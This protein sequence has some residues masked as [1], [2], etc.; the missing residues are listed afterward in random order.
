MFRRTLLFAV[1]VVSLATPSFGAV[2]DV[3]TFLATGDG[4]TDDSAAVQA[5]YNCAASPAGGTVIF[6]SG[7]PATTNIGVYYLANTVSVSG[8]HITTR[9][10]DVTLKNGNSGGIGSR[11][12]LFTGSH[13]TFDGSVTLDQN[14]KAVY[15]V[16]FVG[17]ASPLAPVTNIVWKAATDVKRGGAAFGHA[18]SAYLATDMV[19]RNLRTS[20]SVLVYARNC[21]RYEISNVRVA[22]TAPVSQQILFLADAITSHSSMDITLSDIDMDLGNQNVST[23]I[24]VGA[25]THTT[26]AFDGVKISNV[27][28]RNTVGSATPSDGI[29]LIDC[30]NAT[31]SNL[32]L[33]DID[34]NGINAAGNNLVLTNIVGQNCG[35]ACVQIHDASN[36]NSFS[37][38]TLTNIIVVNGGNASGATGPAA[39]GVALAPRYLGGGAGGSLSLVR[40]QNVHTYGGSTPYGLYIS[41]NVTY[42]T[43]EGLSASGSIKGI[44]LEDPNATT[45]AF[46]TPTADPWTS[47][48]MA[49]SYYDGTGW[50]RQD[51]AR[52]AGKLSADYFG[53]L[54]MQSAAA[55]PNPITWST[56]LML[57]SNG[58]LQWN[59]GSPILKHLSA[60]FGLNL[61][62]PASVPGCVQ[63]AA[64]TLTGA[65]VGNPVAAGISVA[66]PSNQQLTAVVTAAGTVVFRVCQFSG[67]AVDPDGGGATYRADVWQH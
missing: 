16:D 64:Q 48:L 59:G 23:V 7:K 54:F 20:D 63:S 49:N 61:A 22:L 21:R 50:A 67:A 18:M 38:V 31:V 15:A 62:A 25:G 9:F 33:R 1:T 29:D 40:L 11:M 30:N 28:I 53:R 41:K 2:C 36:P 32:V 56:K 13:L 57:D 60:A 24:H 55:G 8:S 35:A 42:V 58:S 3:T 46:D 4:I 39:S 5:A 6:P 17:S 14:N 27:S 66:L 65:A 19:I 10:E 44:Q 52:G 12:L 34:I 26:P 47:Q 37:S 51:V 45:I 43:V